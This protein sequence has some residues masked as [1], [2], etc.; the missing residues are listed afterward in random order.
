MQDPKLQELT[1]S[2]PLTLKEEYEMQESWHVDSN[3]SIV[4]KNC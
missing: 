1:G 3:S 2:E 4:M